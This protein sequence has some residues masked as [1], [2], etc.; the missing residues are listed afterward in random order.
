MGL[1]ETAYWLS[2]FGVFAFS[3]FPSALLCVAAGRAVGFWV[4]ARSDFSLML[5]LCWSYLLSM[6]TLSILMASM[7]SRPRTVNIISF[8]MFSIAVIQGFLFPMLGKWTEAVSCAEAIANSRVLVVA[9]Q[10][11]TRL[12]TTPKTGFSRSSSGSSPGRI[13]GRLSRSSSAL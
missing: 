12:S 13:S 10:V 11:C 4:F 5:M 1:S 7:F 3:S 6:S 2:W 9:L 8:L